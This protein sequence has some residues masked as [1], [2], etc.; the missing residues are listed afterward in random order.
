MTSA[1]GEEEE[2]T[3]AVGRRRRASGIWTSQVDAA[4]DVEAEVKIDGGGWDRAQDVARWRMKT[5]RLRGES[6]RDPRPYL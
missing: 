3:E 4:A 1:E 6:E 2:L 5:K